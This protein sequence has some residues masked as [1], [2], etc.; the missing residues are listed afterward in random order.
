[1][2]SSASIQ[3]DKGKILMGCQELKYTRALVRRLSGECSRQRGQQGP[4]IRLGLACS[5]KSKELIWLSYEQDEVG[6]SWNQNNE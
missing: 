3:C 6:R 1:M 2:G 5:A 4:E